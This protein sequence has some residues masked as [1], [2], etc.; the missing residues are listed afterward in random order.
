MFVGEGTLPQDLV[1]V[2]QHAPTDGSVAVNDVSNS[3]TALGLWGPN[4]RKVLEKVTAADVSNEG[5]PYM[6]ARWIDVG[7]ARGSGAAHLLRRRVG[8]GIACA[9][10][11][12]PACVGYIVGCRARI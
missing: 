10:G 2:R 1:W 12:G 7:M 5:F 9:N 4:A 11:S 3:Y 6:T 8:L